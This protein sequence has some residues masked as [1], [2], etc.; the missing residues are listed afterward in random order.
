MK[1]TRL[2]P[3]FALFA[4]AALPA[5]ADGIPEPKQQ[6]PA[7]LAVHVWPDEPE[8]HAAWPVLEGYAVDPVRDRAAK[9]PLLVRVPAALARCERPTPTFAFDSDVVTTSD[10]QELVRLAGCLSKGPLRD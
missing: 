2:I 5:C 6:P 8:F 9:G 10:E 7:P 1:K 3:L 4:L